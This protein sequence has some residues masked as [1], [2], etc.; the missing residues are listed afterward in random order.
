MSIIISEVFADVGLVN[1][2][3]LGCCKLDCKISNKSS[4]RSNFGVGFRQGGIVSNNSLVECKI[5]CGSGNCDFS[6]SLESKKISKVGLGSELGSF[7]N[8]VL[9]SL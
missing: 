5:G 9:G 6:L 2:I 8:S 3:G 1:N 4:I 7:L